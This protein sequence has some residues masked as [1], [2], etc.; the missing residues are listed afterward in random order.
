MRK[1]VTITKGSSLQ[2]LI[3]VIVLLAATSA[4]GQEVTSLEPG[5]AINAAGSIGVPTVVPETGNAASGERGVAIPR[6]MD[7]LLQNARSSPEINSN[8]VFGANRCAWDASNLVH[9]SVIGPLSNLAQLVRDDTEIQQ[10]ERPVIL[11]VSAGYSDARCKTHALRGSYS[12]HWE[13]RALDLQLT[14]DPQ[15][16]PRSVVLQKL[17]RLTFLAHL[18]G[19]TWSHYEESKH[20]HVSTRLDISSFGLPSGLLDPALSPTGDRI[21]FSEGGGGL[22]TMNSDGSALAQVTFPTAGTDVAERHRSPRVGSGGQI[23]FVRAISSTQ[24]VRLL[25]DSDIFIAGLDGNGILAYADAA[26][27]TFYEE[28]DGTPSD[29][30]SDEVVVSQRV[31]NDGCC[32]KIIS[33]TGF[34]ILATDSHLFAHPRW[35]PGKTAVAYRTRSGTIAIADNS[36]ARLIATEGDSP[37]W[38]NLGQVLYLLNGELWVNKADGSEP[39]QMTR[40]SSFNLSVGAFD[41]ARSAPCLLLIENGKIVRIRF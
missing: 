9:A 28:A 38:T 4:L 41:W 8:V 30:E 6:Y 2:S 1:L 23:V 3:V 19:F 15:R 32:I 37:G 18:A 40:A 35:N 21:F 11:V 33:S 26:S 39:F 31:N 10:F 20:I 36:S 14:T 22:W 34:R 27:P 16:E 24:G 17:G 7:T 29:T 25:F 13:G 12:F 5:E